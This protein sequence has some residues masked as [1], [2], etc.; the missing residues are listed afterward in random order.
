MPQWHK[1]A[2][3]DGHRRCRYDEG[4]ARGWFGLWASDVRKGRRM[5]PHDRG[6]WSY[7]VPDAT[8]LGPFGGEC[9][10]VKRRMGDLRE[11]V[12]G[13]KSSLH[14]QVY[15]RS[16]LVLMD[17]LSEPGFARWAIKQPA[18]AGWGVATA[19]E[20]RFSV[21]RW[22]DVSPLLVR[23]R[24]CQEP[25]AKSCE[26]CLLRDS[27]PPDGDPRDGGADCERHEL[28]PLD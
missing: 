18:L 5:F 25:T 14:R 3:L 23:D 8:G 22:P 2:V 9:V 24:V 26:T 21:V 19:D 17:L 16:W 12:D 27:C 15:A 11:F 20:E 4:V 6:R 1:R 13:G 10:E 7:L 28:A